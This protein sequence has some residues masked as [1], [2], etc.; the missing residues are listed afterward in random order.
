MSENSNQHHYHHHH[1]KEDDA[2]RFKRQ[3]LNSIRMKKVI[4]KWAFRILCVI[5]ALLVIA[6]VLVNH[7]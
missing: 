3:A 4:A 6:A 5:A 1:H 2:T 7:L